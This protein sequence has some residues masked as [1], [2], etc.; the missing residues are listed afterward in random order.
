[1]IRA[2]AKK[3]ADNVVVSLTRKV[4]E[5]EIALSGARV[6]VR[7]LSDA[8]DAKTMQ[9]GFLREQLAEAEKRIAELEGETPRERDAAHLVEEIVALC[10]RL[11]TRP[12]EELIEVEASVPYE[13]GGCVGEELQALLAGLRAEKVALEQAAG[14]ALT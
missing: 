14:K 10:N 1:V 9:I 13:G 11:M 3:F 4:S 6:D 12:V 5:L 7:Q 2:L 8:R